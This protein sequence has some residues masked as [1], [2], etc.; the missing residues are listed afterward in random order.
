LSRNVTVRL[1]RTVFVAATAAMD[2]GAAAVSHLVRACHASPALC[3]LG[4]EALA[5]TPIQPER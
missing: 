4:P 5:P 2:T 3:A 1:A